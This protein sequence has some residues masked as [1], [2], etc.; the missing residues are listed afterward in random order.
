LRWS[1]GVMT[2]P[3]RRETTLPFTL[4]T[5]EKAGFDQPRLF[6]DGAR[7]DSEY[8]HLGLRTTCHFPTIRTAANWT[9]ALY[10]L[11]TR[12]P[13]ANRFA[14]FQ[15]DIVI[16]K[17]TKQ[18]LDTFSYGTYAQKFY[19][20]LHT[21]PVNEEEQDGEKGFRP[22]DHVGFYP[23]NQL[24]KGALALVFDR[25][26]VCAL[27]ST[28]YLT[29]RFQDERRGHQSIDGGVVTAMTNVGY[30]E[31]VHYP[32]LVQHIGKIST[33][34]HEKNGVTIY[35]PSASFPGESFDAMELVCSVKKL[36]EHSKVLVSQIY[37][38]PSGWDGHVDAPSE[39]KS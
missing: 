32:S 33:M 26:A 18:Y 12:D 38:L 36:P 27:F 2:V 10:E 16:C 9:L 37:G 5:L 22:K 11:Y 4:E 23:S 3:S 39:G 30:K 15:D 17:N 31:H 29:R 1:Y 14:V 25:E 24:G 13:A 21:F 28:D 20:N 7:D 34:G 35:P 8:R 6:I 19:W